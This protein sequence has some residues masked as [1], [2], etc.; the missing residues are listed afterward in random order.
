M[1]VIIIMEKNKKE[2]LT[3]EAIKNM[4][5]RI[6]EKDVMLDF[7]LARIFEYE[8]R[9]FNEQVKEILIDLMKDQYLN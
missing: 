3:N 9:R 7:D 2:I 6:R 4:V 8:T 5:H 1:G